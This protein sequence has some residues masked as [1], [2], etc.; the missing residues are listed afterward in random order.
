M[1]RRFTPR[2]ASIAAAGVSSFWCCSSCA[3]T[4]SITSES[5]SVLMLRRSVSNTCWRSASVLIRLPL[6]ASA[7]P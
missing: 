4:L 3:N 1:Q 6:C 7:M 2:T 5:D